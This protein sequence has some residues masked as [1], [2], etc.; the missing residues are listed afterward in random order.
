MGRPTPTACGV[1]GC[2]ALTKWHLDE[3]LLK[4]PGKKYWLGRAVDEDGLVLDIL[5]QERRNEEAA[6]AF[7]SRV[8]AAA[9]GQP[10]V[11]VADK[12]ASYGPAVKRVLP[13]AEHRRHKR[14]NNR[15]EKLPP[16]GA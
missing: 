12:L 13:T 8:L 11:M 10:R 3:M 1:D 15:A 7:L 5:V 14:V 9:G 4:I 2:D 6:V 16:A